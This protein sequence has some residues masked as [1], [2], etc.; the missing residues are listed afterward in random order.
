MPALQTNL[1]VTHPEA[2]LAEVESKLVGIEGLPVV[3]DQGKVGGCWGGCWRATWALPG[4]PQMLQLPCSS[5][6]RSLTLRLMPC[7]ALCP[8]LPCT[9]LIHSALACPACSWWGWCRGRTS[10]RRAATSRQ[11]A[12]PASCPLPPCRPAPLLHCGA[13]PSAAATPSTPDTCPF[14]VFCRPLSLLCL[15]PWT[16]CDEQ[17]RDRPQGRRQGV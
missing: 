2:P 11:V 5:C 7:P 9:V 6:L 10:K 3:D 13:L 17:Q 14:S 15:L 1:V 4:W 16:G 8:A 12:A